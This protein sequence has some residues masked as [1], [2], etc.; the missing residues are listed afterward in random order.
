[1]TAKRA[2]KKKRPAKKAAKKAPARKSPPKEAPAEGPTID[3]AAAR[4]PKSKVSARDL[5]IIAR[6]LAL[7]LNIES[8][9]NLVGVSRSSIYSWRSHEPFDRL[10]CLAQ[11]RGRERVVKKLWG[12]IDRGHFG[13]ISF[14]LRT[15]AAEFQPTL[16]ER[17]MLADEDIY[18]DNDCFL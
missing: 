7:G 5:R 9:G 6:G 1:M 11:A 16:A 8:V 4:P 10:V 3:Y 2:T 13:A 17:E 18:D 14:W 15:R 12:L